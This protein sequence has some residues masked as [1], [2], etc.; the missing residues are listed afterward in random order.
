[1]LASDSVPLLRP[2]VFLTPSGSGTVHV[3]SSRGTDLIAAPGIAAW[4]DRL[5][6]FLDG[7]RTVD[8]LV[9]GL[10]ENRRTVVLRVL[11]L[12]DAHGLLDERSA[13]GPDPRAAAHARMRVLLLGDPEHTR[14][15][16]DALRLTG[17]HTTTAVEDLDAART[18]VA[19]GGHDALVLL[20]A[21]AD[22]PSVA[23]LDEDCRRH[24]LWFAAAVRDAAAWWLG[25][26][27]APG[28]ER[29]AGGW[30]GAWLRV[31]GT[32]AADRTAE[33]R[34]PVPRP[35]PG[36]EA[37]AVLLA[38][39]FRQAVLDPAAPEPLVRLDAAALTTTRHRYRP[40]PAALPAAP[41][42]AETFLARIAALRGGPTVGDDEF[43]RRAADCI[44]PRAGLLA[45]LD[46]GGLPQF[47]RHASSALVRDPHTGRAGHRVHATG[48]DFT[49]ARLRTA[50][51]ALLHYAQLALD[52]RRFV[53]TPEGPALW[54]WSPEL[55]TARLVPAASVSA[56]APRVPRGLGAGATFDEALAAALSDL[57]GPTRG[58]LIVPLDH[59]PAAT[60]VLPHLLKAVRCDD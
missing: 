26:S 24:G 33:P 9:G 56:Q 46:E 59:D 31:H 30:A 55:G 6:P 29:A 36:A 3:R 4:L 18:A 17:L 34:T 1:M 41:E 40:H 38:H 19:A 12:L 10:D 23:R 25:P 49:A 51:R 15:Q 57:R 52:P 14:A 53:D 50:R 28:A 48:R 60:E 20:T 42:S 47:P 44:D 11:R 13:A 7:T 54:A 8:Q 45:E 39:R 2:D 27:L 5:A 43:S 35:A 22:T 21:D 58:A 32:R 37:A 16:A